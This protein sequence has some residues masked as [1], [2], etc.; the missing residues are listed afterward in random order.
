M[1]ALLVYLTIGGLF[2]LYRWWRRD[3]EDIEQTEKMIAQVGVKPFL[4]ALTVTALLFWPLMVVGAII[5]RIVL[6]YCWIM[7]RWLAWRV[8]HLRL[9]QLQIRK[10]K[11]A[12]AAR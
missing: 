2:L 4:I 6:V 7:M 12:L 9:R 1:N 11:R 8:R 3:Q 10:A 5:R